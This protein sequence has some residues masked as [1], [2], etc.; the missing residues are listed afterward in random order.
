LRSFFPT[1]KLP[2][3][4]TTTKD[5]ISIPNII[6][7]VTGLYFL[8]VAAIGEGSVY[9]VVGGLL[10]FISAGLAAEKDWI[11]SWPWRLATAAFSAVILVV[12]LGS[13]FTVSNASAVIVASVL[14]NGVL[15]LLMVGLLLVTAKDL[16]TRE[17]E[18]EEEEEEEPEAKK[19]RLTYEI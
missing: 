7:I 2:P 1:E 8:A 19:K 5:L 17:G 16:V 6:F 15:F 18:E 4:S 14:I 11:F 3:L 10:C 9:S 13:D 12:Q